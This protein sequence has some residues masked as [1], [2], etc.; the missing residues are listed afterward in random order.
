M[1][2]SLLGFLSHRDAGLGAY[3]LLMSGWTTWGEVEGWLRLR[4]AVAIAVAAGAMADLWPV[5]AGARLP[6]SQPAC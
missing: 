2:G 3:Y 5:A 6:E 1:S 4:S